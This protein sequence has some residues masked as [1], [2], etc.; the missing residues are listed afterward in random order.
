MITT[1]DNAGVLQSPAAD[2]STLIRTVSQTPPHIATP[3]SL[4]DEPLIVIEPTGSWSALDF[5]E[6]WAHRELLY[7]LT[8]RDIKVRYKQTAF[9]AAWVIL[10]PLL[11]TLIFTIFLGMLAR[12]PSDGA[13]YPLMVY[14]GLLPWTFF[15]GAVLNS[16]NSLLGNANLI[17]KVYFPRMIIPAAAIGA[18]LVDFATGFVILAGMMLYYRVPL[19]R[20]ALMLPALVA[21]TTLLALGLGVL[22]SAL[23]VK[24]RDIGFALPVLMQFWMYVSPVIYPANLVPARWRGVYALNPLVGVVENFRAALLPGKQFNWYALAVTTIVTLILLTC[25]AYIFK[26]VEKSFADTI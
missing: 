10:Q 19:T 12:V 16:S 26:R 20:N 23:N 15:S 22:L 1:S 18:R 6:L 3:H 9:G 2:D 25:A 4:P 7:F 24:R 14:I 21:L 13:P 5:R 11:T 17:T 8:W